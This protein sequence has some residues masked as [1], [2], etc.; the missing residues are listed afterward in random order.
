MRANFFAALNSPGDN[1]YLYDNNGSLVD[2]VGWS[3]LHNRGKTMCRV[4]NGN[5][6]RD[7]FDDTSSIAASWIFDCAPSMQFVK[8][9]RGKDTGKTEYGDFGG[10]IYFNLTLTNKQSVDDTVF[11]FNSTLRG[12]PVTILDETGTFI[13]SEI[14]LPS[15]AKVNITVIVVLPSTVPFM[16]WDNITFT[17]QSENNAMYR[18][19]MTIKVVV[20]PFVWPEKFLTPQQIYLDGTGHDEIF[21]ITLNLSGLGSAIEFKKPQDVIFC[22]DTSGSM[23]QRSI[24]IIKIGLVGYVDK[25]EKPDRGALVIFNSGAWLMNPLSDDYGQLKNDISNI[26]SPG[27][28]TFMGEALQVAIN[29]L[30]LNGNRSSI[31]VIILL[32]D[33]YGN[34]FVDPIIEAGRAALGN[35]TIFTIGLGDSVDEFTLILIADITGGQY[36]KADDA[37]QIPEIYLII[38]AYIGD[39]AGRDL[40]I[41]D[42]TPMVRDVL[43]PWIILVDGSFSI[44][45]EMNYV[46]DTG[47]RILEWN[48]SQIAI[49]ES[50]EVTFQVKSTRLGWIRANDLDGS[51]IYYVDYFD[52]EVFKLFPE[53]R[54]NVLPPPPLPPKLYIDILT[55]KDDIFLYWDEPPSPGTDHYL[56]YRATS[57]TGFDF[58]LPWIDTNSSLTG[59]D[60]IDG[61]VIPLRT[62]WN[63]TEAADPGRAEYSEQL[64]YCIR[65]VNYLGEISHTSR[66]VGKWTKIFMNENTT[67]SLPLEPLVVR[68]TEFYAQDM[69]AIFIKWMNSTHNWVQH[70]K[71]EIGDNTNV[72][73]GK[74]YEVSF[75]SVDTKYTFLG[76][77]GAMIR[78]NSG[79]FIGFDYNSDAKSLSVAV[80]PVSGDVTLTWDQP[81][82]MNSDDFYKV[83]YSTIRDGFDGVEGSDYKLLPGGTISFNDPRTIVHAGGALLY[84]QIYYM[85]IPVNEFGVKGASTYSI[86]VWTAIYMQEYDTIGIPLILDSYPTADWYC[87]RID[88]AVGINYFINSIVGWGWHST[89]M[90]Q[91]AYDPV[92]EMMEGYQLSTSGATKYTFIG[93]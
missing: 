7:G 82:G 33:G 20:T 68:D 88:D 84:N 83:Y 53:C 74:G 15:G 8:V 92:L 39:L 72:E 46:N 64:Y 13:I 31:Q 35:I 28:S 81:M 17:I 50:W 32:S 57:P 36:F 1:V 43:P 76:M 51:R 86:G 37:S 58:S 69:N 61:F 73:V 27:G 5:G 11:I 40:N 89:R 79:G 77:P 70:D 34:G 25:M 6:T 12:Y 9:S 16:D 41:F 47:Y 23:T 14:F 4:P 45:P 59:V 22:V 18:D 49:G 91:G 65:T 56:I 63:H 24:D 2:M 80:D 52:T 67:F 44:N 3:S 29:E 54:V 48:I 85:I 66:T 42:A 62:T 55:N 19:S 21:T 60:P 87:D 38:A 90:P 78:Y 30:V 10:V 93:H 26:P 71:G 75:A